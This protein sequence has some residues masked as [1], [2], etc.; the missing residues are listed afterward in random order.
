MKV[1]GYVIEVEGDPPTEYE[2]NDSLSVPG[3]GRELT[4]AD[5]LYIVTHIRT[6]HDR[7]AQSGDTIYTYPRV[8]VRRLGDAPER[9]GKDDDSDDT[10]PGKPATV[11]SF[12]LISLDDYQPTQV[13]NLADIRARLTHE[14]IEAAVQAPAR[15]RVVAV[16]PEPR[17]PWGAARTLLDN[18]PLAVPR[19]HQG[20]EIDDFAEERARIEHEVYRL[21]AEQQKTIAVPGAEPAAPLKAVQDP[22]SPRTVLPWGSRQ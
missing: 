21:R 5:S 11:L 15:R 20:T 1:G 22:S 2:A 7:A 10:S 13:D 19:E 8:F 6:E 12:K 16:E 14:T 3:E 17:E 4:I 18:V 9:P